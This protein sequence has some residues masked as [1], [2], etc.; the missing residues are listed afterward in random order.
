MELVIDLISL[1]STYD[2]QKLNYIIKPEFFL[3]LK[4]GN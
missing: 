3:L 4:R 1:S 2:L